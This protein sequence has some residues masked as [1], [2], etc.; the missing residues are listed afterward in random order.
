MATEKKASKA[1]GSMKPK[2]TITRSPNYPAFDLQEAI[3][4]ARILYDKDHLAGSSQ[5]SALQHLGFNRAEGKL[6]GPAARTISTLKKFGLTEER[7]GRIHLSQD[8]L[9][10]IL[11]NETDE[12]HQRSVKK[13]ALQPSIYSKIYSKYISGLP[14]DETLRSELIREDRFN[15]NQVDGFLT[16]FRKTVAFAG[17]QFGSD[18]K[19]EMT[20]RNAVDT[21][22]ERITPRT[23]ELSASGRLPKVSSTGSSFTILLK[24]QNQATIGFSRL[25]LEKSDLETIRSWIDLMADNL[26]EVPDATS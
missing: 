9:D 4:K 13:C 14:S 6:S 19:E 26:A 10:I 8:A 16:D 2:R 3:G 25:P 1:P 20:E 21:A 17:L 22:G 15:P 24:K 5:E 7:V 18:E 11:Y 23:G 12:R